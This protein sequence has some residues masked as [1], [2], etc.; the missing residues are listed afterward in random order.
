MWTI[1]DQGCPKVP[2]NSLFFILEIFREVLEVVTCL[3]KERETR[4]KDQ[5]GSAWICNL[6]PDHPS[7]CAQACE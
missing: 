2:P 4:Q 5:V 3:K 7:Q 6:T 1:I